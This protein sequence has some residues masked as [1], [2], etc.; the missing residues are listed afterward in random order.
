MRELVLLGRRQG[1]I[2]IPDL[3]HPVLDVGRELIR[4]CCSIVDL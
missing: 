3:V 4:E 1:H 2:G